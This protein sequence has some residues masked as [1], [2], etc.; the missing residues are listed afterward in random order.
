LPDNYYQADGFPLT[1]TLMQKDFCGGEDWKSI[2]DDLEQIRMTYGFLEQITGDFS[3]EIGRG[4]FGVVYKVSLV[5]FLKKNKVS[6]AVHCT[7]M[8]KNQCSF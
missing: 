1:L 5:P 4:K 7:S 2:M 3:T 6:L 8:K